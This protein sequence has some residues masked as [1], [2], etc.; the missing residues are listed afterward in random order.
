MVG[1]EQSL[2][3][4]GLR[5]ECGEVFCQGSLLGIEKYMR[6]EKNLDEV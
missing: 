5:I 2:L 3:L 4:P 6:L 1:H